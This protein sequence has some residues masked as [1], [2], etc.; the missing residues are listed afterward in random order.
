[1]KIYHGSIDKVE[2]PEIRI[3]VLLDAKGKEIANILFF[4]IHNNA[5]INNIAYIT[6]YCD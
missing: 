4:H 3:L 1:M 6:K 2:K 5:K